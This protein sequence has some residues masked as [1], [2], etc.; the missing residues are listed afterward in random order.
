MV[1]PQDGCFLKQLKPFVPNKTWF[2]GNMV[3]F[4][5]VVFG[6]L[7][8]KNCPFQGFFFLSIL[9]VDEKENL[10]YNLNL[11]L[12]GCNGDFN[13]YINLFLLK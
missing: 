9:F 4:K 11:G 3:L 2:M 13:H 1:L 7:T 12:L 5:E 10:R 6:Q 8:S